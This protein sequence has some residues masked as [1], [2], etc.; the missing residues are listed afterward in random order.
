MADRQQVQL[1]ATGVVLTVL[2]VVAALSVPL[3]EARPAHESPVEAATGNLSGPTADG[4]SDVP[5]ATVPLASAPSSV[6]NAN[7]TTIE[8]VYV[9]AAR[10]EERLYL[11]LQWADA[12]RD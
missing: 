2:V 10:G 1:V 6:P 12:T 8:R 7:D 4:W 9:Q 5:Q 11:R 3:V